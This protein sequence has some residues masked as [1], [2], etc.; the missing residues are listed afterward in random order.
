MNTY[1]DLVTRARRLD[2]IDDEERNVLLAK[3]TQLPV[4]AQTELIHAREL[5]EALHRLFLT[6][7]GEG[8]VEEDD[9]A[10]LDRAVQAAQS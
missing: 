7:S 8:P 3:A 6:E 10:L 2:M 9:L 1:G 4:Q 5:R